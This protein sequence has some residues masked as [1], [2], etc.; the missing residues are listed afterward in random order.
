MYT[1]KG[2]TGMTVDVD[3]RMLNQIDQIDEARKQ[4]KEDSDTGGG[5]TSFR[6]TEKDNNG[7][8]TNVATVSKKVAEEIASVDIEAAAFD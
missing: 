1:D 2:V 5:R 4:L 8:V 7:N 6:I 3:Q